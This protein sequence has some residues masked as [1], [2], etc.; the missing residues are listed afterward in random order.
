MIDD[1]FYK[2]S[3]PQTLGEIASRTGTS[4]PIEG[5]YDEV[6]IAPASL[7]ESRPGEITFFSNKRLNCLLYTSD[8]ADE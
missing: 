3:P 2:L 7:A 1:R 5:L 4:L 6:I 8:A